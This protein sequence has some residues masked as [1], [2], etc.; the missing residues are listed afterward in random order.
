[1]RE[2]R[3]TIITVGYSLVFILGKSNTIE[4]SQSV[5]EA[6]NVNIETSIHPIAGG[7]KT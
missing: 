6:A 7:G 4:D 3:K 2:E 5:P 1:M